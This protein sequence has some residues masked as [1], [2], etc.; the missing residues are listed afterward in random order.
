MG[1]DMYRENADNSNDGDGYFRLN[2]WG[3]SEARAILA[4]AGVVRNA[5]CPSFPRYE[6]F[7]NDDAYNDAVYALVAAPAPGDAPG[8][9]AFKFGTNDGWLVLPIEIQSGIAYANREHPYWRAGLAEWI[10]EFVT[11][12]EGSTDGFRVW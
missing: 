2:V 12:M 4:E 10:E 3:M 7:P 5:P 6:D 1:Y 9:P 8:I 11:W